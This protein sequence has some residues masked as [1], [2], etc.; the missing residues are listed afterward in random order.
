MVSSA[1]PCSA[2]AAMATAKTSARGGAGR[3]PGVSVM[4]GQLLGGDGG[5]GKGGRWENGVSGEK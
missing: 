5:Y 3:R 4:R 2:M 1:S